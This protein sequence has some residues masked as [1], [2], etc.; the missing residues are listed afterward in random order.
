[1]QQ[2]K[3]AMFGVENYGFKDPHSRCFAI[4][5]LVAKNPVRAKLD[6]LHGIGRPTLWGYF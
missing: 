2:N 3:I 4:A 5:P 6:R 1:M